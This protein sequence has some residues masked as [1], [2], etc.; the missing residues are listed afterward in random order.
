MSAVFWCL[1]CG[2]PLSAI[3]AEP[4]TCIQCGHVQAPPLRVGSSQFSASTAVRSERVP[5]S[6]GRS[7]ALQP[8]AQSKN[9]PKHRGTAWRAFLVDGSR[10]QPLTFCLIGLSLADL[11]LTYILLKLHPHAYESNPVAQWFFQRWNIF[12]MAIFKF[13]LVGVVVLISEII[14]RRHPRRG[15]WVLVSACAA[16][17]AVVFYSLRLISASL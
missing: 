1:K 10:V 3:E 8:R 4:V 5:S 15:Q 13:A 9:A 17:G 11:L 16:A 2:A 7:G 6:G 14:E 12:G